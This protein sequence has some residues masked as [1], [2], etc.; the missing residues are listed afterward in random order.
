MSELVVYKSI[1]VAIFLVGV[2]VAERLSPAVTAPKESVYGSRIR[3]NLGLWLCNSLVSPLV[4]LPITMYAVSYGETFGVV[5]RG[6]QVDEW[7]LMLIDL[8]IL[9]C[10]IYWWHRANHRIPVLWRFHRIHHLDRWLDVT[11]AVRFHLGELVLSAL[12]R[13]VLIICLGIP[14]L[15]VIIFETLVLMAAGFHHSNIR[16]PSVVEGLLSKIIITPSIHWVH[17]HVV[18]L[19]TDSNYGTLLSVWDRLF[20]SQSQNRRSDKMKIGL[21]GLSDLSFIQLLMVPFRNVKGLG[22][23]D[24]SQ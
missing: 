17:H 13:A 6:E 4:I 15:T 14:L 12:A 1:L 11:S 9:D 18:Q 8:A 23:G 22:G 10:W 7:V 5:W 16:M 20:G 2:F 3:K 19:D 24:D 21:D